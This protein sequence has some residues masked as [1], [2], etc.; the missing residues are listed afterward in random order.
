MNELDIY[1]VYNPENGQWEVTETRPEAATS[2]F[3]VMNGKGDSKYIWDPSNAVEVEAAGE[4]FKS[5]KRKGMA[6]FRVEGDDFGKG[7]QVRE[8]DPAMG[9]LIFAPALQGG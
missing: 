5:F 2:E 7:A 8:F 1:L 6:A 3:A 4:L 9:R